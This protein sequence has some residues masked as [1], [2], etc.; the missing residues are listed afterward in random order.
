MAKITM[1]K[2]YEGEP[3]IPKPR[4]K[5]L[6]QRCQG[7]RWGASEIPRLRRDWGA[8][9]PSRQPESPRS[10]LGPGDVLYPPA[11]R[12][13]AGQS[14]H[15]RVLCHYTRKRRHDAGR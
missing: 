8:Y 15:R 13:R 9:R 10:E 6:P 7:A 14:P 11:R 1:F 2:G 3:P 12:A 5:V 4:E